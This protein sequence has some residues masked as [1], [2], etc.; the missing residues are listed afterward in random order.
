VA[1]IHSAHLLEHFPLEET[2]RRL[3]PY[4][5]HLL[6][7]GG[8]FTVIV[9]DGETMLAEHAAGRLSFEEL[10]LVVFGDQEYDG[11][12]HFNMFSK[13]SLSNLLG[14]AG[15]TD[16]CVVEEGRRNGVCYEMEFSARRPSDA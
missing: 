8:T 14:D 16:V 5:F 10:R 13:T 15:F 6:Q 9:P 3:L 11:D 7:P 2:R 1:V 4:W 12:F